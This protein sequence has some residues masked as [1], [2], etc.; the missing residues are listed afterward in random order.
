MTEDEDDAHDEHIRRVK[1][2][3]ARN[4]MYKEA[5]EA[6]AYVDDAVVRKL[7]S[8]MLAEIDFALTTNRSPE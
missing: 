6:G 2:I 7:A 8:D 5:H 3:A 1:A 4:R